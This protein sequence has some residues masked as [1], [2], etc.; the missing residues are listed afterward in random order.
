MPQLSECVEFRQHIRKTETGRQ[1]DSGIELFLLALAIN[2]DQGRI[3]QESPLIMDT[4]NNLVA[5]VQTCNISQDAS[6]T[7]FYL[8]NQYELSLNRVVQIRE[9]MA[10]AEVITVVGHQLSGKDALRPLFERH[11]YH[12]VTFSDMVRDITTT[13]GKDRDNTQD[14]IDVGIDFKKLFGDDILV[15]LA[16]LLAVEKRQNKLVLFGPRV[17]GEAVGKVVAVSVDPNSY[18]RDYRIRFERAMYRAIYDP[19]R[20]A[21]VKAFKNRERQ[22]YGRL[23]EIMES[24]DITLVN[25]AT[26]SEFLEQAERMIFLNEKK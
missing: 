10:Q 4:V 25:N 3:S 2:V 23:S 22:E 5:R 9:K 11:G 13:V 21:D 14:K 1:I 18:L 24:A 17:K 8:G 12:L 6:R 20:R 16:V 15:K 19:G 7:S 26:I